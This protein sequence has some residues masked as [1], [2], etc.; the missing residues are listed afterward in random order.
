MLHFGL[1]L[2]AALACVPGGCAMELTRMETVATCELETCG[3]MSYNQVREMFGSLLMTKK[4]IY[5]METAANENRTQYLIASGAI[6]SVASSFI[7]DDGG[8]C[9]STRVVHI[10]NRTLY[11]LQGQLKT[12]IHLADANTP[13]YQY[14]PHA[15]CVSVGDCKGK[16]IL[17][18]KL[19][20]LLVID[21][22]TGYKF[23]W[24]LI[25]GYCSCKNIY[26]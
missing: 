12:V 24:F 25:P 1:A 10:A 13:S 11:N 2:W 22:A 6:E 26:V 7:D 4:Q 19:T 20:S 23:D 17:E 3:R 16:C 8:A 14:I 5:E 15:S 21:F 18:A 9:C